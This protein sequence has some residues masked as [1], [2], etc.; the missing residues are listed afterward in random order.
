LGRAARQ[1]GEALLLI[2]ELE[3]VFGKVLVSLSLEEYF[4]SVCFLITAA[5]FCRLLFIWRAGGPSL[6]QRREKTE[7][8]KLWIPEET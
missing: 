7:I 5:P 4:S 2:C 6:E 3:P 8:L 1:A